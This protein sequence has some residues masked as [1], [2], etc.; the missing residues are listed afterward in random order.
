M[1]LNIDFEVI[2]IC[3]KLNSE[4]DNIIIKLKIS[5]EEASNFIFRFSPSIFKCDKYNV[6]LK[7]N[8]TGILKGIALLYEDNIFIINNFNEFLADI[9]EG[10]ISIRTTE[11]LTGIM[12]FDFENSL[13]DSDEIVDEFDLKEK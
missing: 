4:D 8:D 9:V 6:V 2:A 13:E 5:K 10:Y 3:R 11:K 12:N 1:K 7:F